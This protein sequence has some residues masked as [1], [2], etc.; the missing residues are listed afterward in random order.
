MSKKRYP[1]RIPRTAHGFRAQ[2]LRA[3]PRG[4][5]WVREW[6]QSI[7]K[8]RL[9][10]RAGRGRAYAETGQVTALSV[11]GGH[12]EATATGSRPQPYTIK[13]DFAQLPTGTTD[14]PSVANTKPNH[15]PSTFQPFN[16]STFQPTQTMP[17]ARIMAGD[18]P[19]SVKETFALA[20]TPLFPTLGVDHFWCSCPDWSHPCKHV[21]AVLLL[22]GDAMVRDPALLLRLRGFPLP[23]V[24]SGASE[25]PLPVWKGTDRLRDA[26]ARIRRRTGVT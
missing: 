20:G 7:E 13:L 6:L 8:M 14:V 18:M 21:V 1:P 9:G 19:A 22:L 17:L 5:W 2:D 10:A 23:G 3:L 25:I 12:V 24:D 4:A 15:P 11:A 16:L 26:L